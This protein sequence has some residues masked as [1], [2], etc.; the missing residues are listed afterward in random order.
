MTI[1]ISASFSASVMA[2]DETINGFYDIGTK[3]NVTITPYAGETQVTATDK[4]IAGDDAME[5]VYV[6]SDRLDVT[7]NGATADVHYGV[8]L[9]EGADLPTKDTEIYYINQETL[10]H[11]AKKY[12]LPESNLRYWRK[13]VEKKLKEFL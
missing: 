3:E 6:D 4:N 11:V 2:A 13:K 12:N 9:V 10:L 7:Y 8:I 1:A 5:S